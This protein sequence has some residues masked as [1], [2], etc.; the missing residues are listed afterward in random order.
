MCGKA[1]S[2][3]YNYLCID[4]TRL[5]KEGKYRLFNESKNTF[6]ECIPQNEVFQF[7]YML[8]PNRNGEDLENLVELSS[9]QKHV[10]GLR[11]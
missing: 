1:W 6:I 7:F 9:L 5:K 11:L 4:M 8:Y 3:R 10:K 2:E